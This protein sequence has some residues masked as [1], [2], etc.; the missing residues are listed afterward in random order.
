MSV[1]E[2]LIAAREALA[3][4]YQSRTTHEVLALIDA[5]LAGSCGDP[6]CPCRDGDACHY[7]DA[8]DGTKAWPQEQLRAQ[9]D[10]ARA[11]LN[12]TIKLLTGIHALLYPPPV[13]T[14]DGRTM[15]F[16]PKGLDADAVLQELSDRIRALPD[17]LLAQEPAPQAETAE[18]PDAGPVRVE[19]LTPRAKP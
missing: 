16:R 3:G 2:A 7:R 10:D 11:R 9:R 8:A 4:G 12:N 13:T 14:G 17:E 5:A 18:P 1:R 19:F 15:V 6:A